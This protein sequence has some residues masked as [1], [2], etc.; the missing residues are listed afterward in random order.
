MY[1]SDKKKCIY[2]LFILIA[3]TL[4][5][6]SLAELEGP[7]IALDSILEKSTAVIVGTIFEIDENAYLPEV[8]PQ[9]KYTVCVE[10]VLFGQVESDYVDFY[11]RGGIYPN[12]EFKQS[13]SVVPWLPIG[14]TFI[15]FFKDGDYVYHPFV[16]AQNAILRIDASS[17][18]N[19]VTDQYGF[20]I[21]KSNTLGLYR[22]LKIAK[23]LTEIAGTQ[24][25]NGQTDSSSLLEN[26]DD[27][28]NDA[29][30]A[31]DL[32]EYIKKIGQTKKKPTNKLK[33]VMVPKTIDYGT[34]SNN[35]K[36]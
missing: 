34:V 1:C 8:G 19:I 28:I 27:A 24:I 31:E 20:L 3:F 4:P 14:E 21:N 9:T 33:K 22:S 11:N 26:K 12:K 36:E 18:K 15:F 2:I 5:M 17:N 16:R 13:I 29:T 6:Q 25:E 35:N 7:D 30:T 10:E 23:S 32:F